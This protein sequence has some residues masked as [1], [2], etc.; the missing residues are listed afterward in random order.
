MTVKFN[1]F[2]NML[3]EISKTSTVSSNDISSGKTVNL[4]PC[5]FNF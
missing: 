5:K 4:F 1:T 3:F 2:R